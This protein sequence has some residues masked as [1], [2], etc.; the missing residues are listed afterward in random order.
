MIQQNTYIQKEIAFTAP[1]ISGRAAIFIFIDVSI[2]ELIVY[3]TG[4]V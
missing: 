1:F 4:E 2:V 3:V